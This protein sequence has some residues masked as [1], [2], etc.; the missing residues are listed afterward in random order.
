[1]C[2]NDDVCMLMIYEGET[3]Y[4]NVFGWCTRKN[5]FHFISS[6]INKKVT[7]SIT[8]ESKLVKILFYLKLFFKNYS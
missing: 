1:M 5:S 7:L 4:N 2:T 8:A 3:Q 6:I